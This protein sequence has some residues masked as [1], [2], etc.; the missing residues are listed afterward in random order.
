MLENILEDLIGG[1]LSDNVLVQTVTGGVLTSM[2]LEFFRRI[3]RRSGTQTQT[4]VAPPPERRGGGFF[5]TL[6][7]LI[8]SVIGGVAV[9]IIGGRML[10]EAGL[11]K[12]PFPLIRM[13]LLIG[14]TIVCWSLLLAF[15]R[16]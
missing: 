5:S 13:G 9:A 6:F 14:G 4:Q 10:V 16:R 11:L 2:I 8:L 15:R 12:P 7:R 1:L 3:S